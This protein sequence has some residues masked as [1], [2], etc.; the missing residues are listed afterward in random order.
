MQILSFNACLIAAHTALFTSY[1]LLHIHTRY[2][3][4]NYTVKGVRPRGS[5]KKA[6]SENVEKDVRS[7]IIQGTREGSQ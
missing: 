5:T 4:H 2:K 1:L 7:N 3:F 6:R